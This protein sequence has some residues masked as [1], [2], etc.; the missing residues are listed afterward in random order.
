MIVLRSFVITTESITPGLNGEGQGSA[1]NS[2]YSHSQQPDPEDR[3][4]AGGGGAIQCGDA[5]E[6]NA[7]ETAEVRS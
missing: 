7:P 3:M 5:G 4:I 2:G 1:L 6:K